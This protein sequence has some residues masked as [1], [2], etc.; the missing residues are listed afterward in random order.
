MRPTPTDLEPWARNVLTQRE[1]GSTLS[2]LTGDASS[3]RYFRLSIAGDTYILVDA[4]PATEK[5]REFVQVQRLL[6]E[7]G[8]R[9]P[10]ILGVDFERGYML[11]DDLGDRLLL[12]ELDDASVEVCYAR[13][14]GLLHKLAAIS[15]L[16]AA[17]PRYDLALLTEELSRFPAWFVDK[18][19]GIAEPPASW[20]ALESL[21]LESALEQ[22]EVLVHRDFHSRNLMPQTD[23]ELALI[24]FQDAV[25]GPVSY[26][27]VSLLR[28]CYIRWPSERVEAWALRYLGEAQAL[29]SLTDVS[30]A[31][32]MRWFDLMGLER[33][34]KVLGT[35]ARLYLRDGKQAYLADM[36]LVLNYV[37]EMLAKYSAESTA[38]AAAAEWFESE[39]MTAVRRQPWGGSV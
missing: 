9:V 33:H 14:F 35:F 3:R 28:D 15:P 1:T 8:I 20:R 26:D 21:L 22:P 24:D 6:A 16:D 27:L 12:P 34:I 37:T 2:P 4:P 31:Q 19:L 30:D 10:A 29:G 23:G 36:P 38:V 5:N 13:A 39:L 7:A 11:L 18:L 17:W 25:T 32:F